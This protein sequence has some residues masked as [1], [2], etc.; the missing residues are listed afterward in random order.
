[1]ANGNR[2]LVLNCRVTEETLNK[3]D[4]LRYDCPWC[5]RADIIEYVFKILYNDIEESEL[6]ELIY[7]RAHYRYLV[8]DIA[9]SIK[10]R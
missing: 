4:G 2:N 7:Y 5:S 1:M 6:K 8:P 10:K 9:L 3:I